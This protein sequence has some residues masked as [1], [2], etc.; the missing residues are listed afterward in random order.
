[1]NTV[2]AERRAGDPAKLIASSAKIMKDLK[3]KPRFNKL[4][5]IIESAWRWHKLNPDGFT[6]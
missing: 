3:W 2:E 6:E 4:E 1:M 5:Q